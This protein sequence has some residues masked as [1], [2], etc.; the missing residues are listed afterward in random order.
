MIR[1]AGALGAAMHPV[2]AGGR[3][4]P[5]ARSARRSP[6][7]LRLDR[8]ARSGAPAR[9]ALAARPRA[10]RADRARSRADPRAARAVDRRL[11]AGRADL[12]ARRHPRGAHAGQVERA[13]R[14]LRG[15]RRRRVGGA[16]RWPHRAHARRAA[17]LDRPRSRAR[18]V[19]Q[20]GHDRL[21]H[22]RRAAHPPG[23]SRASSRRTSCRRSMPRCRAVYLA[24]REEAAPCGVRIYDAAEAA[25]HFDGLALAAGDALRRRGDRGPD[26]SRGVRSRSD[27]ERGDRRGRHA[28]RRAL[29]ELW[30][31]RLHAGEPTPGPR[32]R[33]R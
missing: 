5:H 33:C 13:P 9:R 12:V 25:R 26:R 15:R 31:R 2:G 14:L 20:R 18:A 11:P 24:L 16:R 29:A 27:H 19:R 1:R 17:P 22:V 23:P 28:D 3:P 8:A 6:A 7:R 30:W 32:R 10:G 21:H 4:T